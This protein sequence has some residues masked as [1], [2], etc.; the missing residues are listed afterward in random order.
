MSLSREKSAH[1]ELEKSVARSN[2]VFEQNKEL[3]EEIR[4]LKQD[5]KN[6]NKEVQKL[7]AKLENQESLTAYDSLKNHNSQKHKNKLRQEDPTKLLADTLSKMG[8]SDIFKTKLTEYE[9]FLIYHDAGLT[10][11]SYRKLKRFLTKKGVADPFPPLRSIVKMEKIY[12][13]RDVFDIDKIKVIQKK[14]D[15]SEVE[16][17]VMVAQLRNIKEFLNRR[18]QNL[19]DNKKLIF[20][21]C[22]GNNIWI[23][24]LGDKGSEEFKLSLAV[25]NVDSPNSSHH[26]VPVAVFDDDESAE[27]VARF[28][29]KSIRQLNDLKEVKLIIDGK[30]VVIPIKQFL[31]GDM[32]YI[33]EML[34]HQGASSKFS[35]MFCYHE[36]KKMVGIY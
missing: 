6:I 26:L 13:S 35:C 9:F 23:A 36:E 24:I 33:Y 21:K 3:K 27:N 2:K 10:R 7:R 29:D 8:K 16:K 18:L 32:K 19:I 17:L 30:E 1:Q 25:G 5:N 14:K 12:G 28:L 20:D 15:E 11:D 34:G 4:V 31:C 22:T